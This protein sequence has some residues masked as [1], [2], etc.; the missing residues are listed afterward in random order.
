MPNLAGGLRE[1]NQRPNETVLT[2]SGGHDIPAAINSPGH[3]QGH[4]LSPGHNGPGG[5]SAHLPAATRYRV[6]RMADPL[7]LIRRAKGPATSPGPS[8]QL[9]YGSAGSAF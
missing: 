9:T 7:R 5:Q 2:P 6:C 4:D 8:S 3:R 1:N